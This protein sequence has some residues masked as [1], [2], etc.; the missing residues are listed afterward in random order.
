MNADPRN[1]CYIPIS[2]ALTPEKWADVCYW[3]WSNNDC[4][5]WNYTHWSK[6]TIEHIVGVYVTPEDAVAF[7]LAFGT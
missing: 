7:K 5:Q 1:S 4:P 6:Q 3:I 2:R